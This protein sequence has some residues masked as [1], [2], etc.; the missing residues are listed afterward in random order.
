MRSLQNTLLLFTLASLFLVGLASAQ[1][2][3]DAKPSLIDLA[4]KYARCAVFVKTPKHSGTGTLFTIPFNDSSGKGS[5]LVI[6]AKH[7][8]A[9]K[10]DAEGNAVDYYDSALVMMRTKNGVIDT[11]HYVIDKLGSKDLDYAVLAPLDVLR[12]FSEYDAAAPSV[13]HDVMSLSDVKPGETAI[14]TGFPFLIGSEPVIPVIQS[15][16]LAYIDSVHSEVFLDIPVSEGSCG[17]PVSCIDKNDEVKLLGV[18][19]E[20][21]P[22]NREAAASKEKHEGKDAPASLGKVILLKSILTEYKSSQTTAH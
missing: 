4:D 2:N 14:V 16:I 9:N 8:L 12:P 21:H 13:N 11:R 17:G 19:T 10:E 7:L 20:Y 5:V 6:T 1:S 18:V 3:F 15:G 22:T